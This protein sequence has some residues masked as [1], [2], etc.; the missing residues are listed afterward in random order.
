[1]GYNMTDHKVDIANTITIGGVFSYLMQFQGEMTMLLLLTGLALNITRLID[2][3]R[4][5]KG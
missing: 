2:W 3:F 5:K 4:N 1:M